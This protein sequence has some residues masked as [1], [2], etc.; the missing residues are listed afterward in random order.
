MVGLPHAAPTATVAAVYIAA[1]ASKVLVTPN[2]ASMQDLMT[3]LH[4]AKKLKIATVANRLPFSSTTFGIQDVA[5]FHVT[6]NLGLKRGFRVRIPVGSPSPFPQ[7]DITF[8]V[9]Q[10]NFQSSIPTRLEPPQ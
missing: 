10:F 2:I 3:L 8:G 6:V 1:R 5:T 4:N 7:E 9:F